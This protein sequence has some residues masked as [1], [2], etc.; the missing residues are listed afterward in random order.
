MQEIT[1][2]RQ[3]EQAAVGNKIAEDLDNPPQQRELEPDM[4]PHVYLNLAAESYLEAGGRV[5]ERGE[6]LIKEKSTSAVPPK[7]LQLIKGKKNQLIL[8]ERKLNQG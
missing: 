6:W 3:Q 2:N 8:R 7:A 5:F 4:I 1:E